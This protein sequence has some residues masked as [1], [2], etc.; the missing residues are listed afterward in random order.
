MPAPRRCIPS[1][2]DISLL[3][4]YNTKYLGL[5]DYD[6]HRAAL[7]EEFYSS[8]LSLATIGNDISIDNAH[9]KKPRASIPTPHQL[10]TRGFGTPSPSHTF[11]QEPTFKTTYAVPSRQASLHLMT[12]SHCTTHIPCSHIYSVHVYASAHMISSGFQSTI[13]PGPF[14]PNSV[15]REHMPF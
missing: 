8:Y 14:R 6:P 11:H 4:E 7:G 9:G 5:P 2:N 3:R 13:L 15:A 12:Y 1:T 10:M